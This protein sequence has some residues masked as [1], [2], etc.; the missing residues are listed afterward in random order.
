MIRHLNAAIFRLAICFAVVSTTAYGESL[1]DGEG[2]KLVEAQCSACHSVNRLTQ[3]LGYSREGWLELIATMVDLST[4]PARREVI[5]EYLAEHFPPND[6]RAP[7]IVEG[8]TRIAFKEWLVPT[9]GQRSRDP[10]E[11]PDG[12]IWWAGQWRN[13]IGRIDPKTGKMRE[14]LLPAGAMP[15]SVTLDRDG[16]VW[17]T[18]NKNG[19]IGRLNPAS[20]E[21]TVYDMPDPAARD[22]HTAVFDSAGILWFTV[23]HANRIGRLN[24]RSGKIKLVTM[25]TAGSRPYGI[26]IDA[27]GTPWVACNGSNCLVK[28]NPKTMALTEVKLPHEATTVRRLDIAAD[29]MIWYVN[30]GRGRLGRFDPRSGEVR[31]WPSPSGPHSHPYAIAV[32][33]GAVWYNESGMRPDPLVRF[34]LKTETFQ[35]WP[36]PSGGIYAGIVRHM[37]P[38]HDGD[39]LIHQSATNRIIR[40]E[41]GEGSTSQ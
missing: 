36:I 28:V 24:P 37:R 22:P 2:R 3:S 14:Y 21:I 35:S 16:G 31:E 25:P 33:D 1:R 13:L 27:S 20:G 23:Q 19:T 10:A 12:N 30:S 11:A 5:V 8:D 38:T 15:H 9:L 7:N 40:V 6:R 18:G 41:I 4:D 17:Y 26:K 32:V 29:G 34:D 39:L